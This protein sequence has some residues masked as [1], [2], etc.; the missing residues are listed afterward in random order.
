MQ[1]KN[2][3]NLIIESINNKQKLEN[4]RI[5]MK[6]NYSSN[7]YGKIEKEINTLV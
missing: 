2:L 7:V 3:F 1:L 4:A 5:N 6:K